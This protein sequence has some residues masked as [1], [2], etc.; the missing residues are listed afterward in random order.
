MK[1]R[2]WFNESRKSRIKASC[3]HFP[4][5]LHILRRDNITMTVLGCKILDIIG[6]L[7]F[8]PDWHCVLIR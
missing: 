8:M 4:T 3:G 5:K 1:G 7:D 6:K 2:N